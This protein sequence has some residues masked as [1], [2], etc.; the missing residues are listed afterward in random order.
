MSAA[1]PVK[2]HARLEFVDILR[3]FA[4][5]GVL[6][7][8]M[9]SF[10][11]YSS[12]PADYADFLDKAIL[13]GIQFFVRAKFYSLFSFLFGWGMSVQMLRAAGRGQRFGPVFARRMAILLIFG[14]IHGMLIWS[15]DILTLYAILGCALLLFRRR[16]ERLLLVAA[17]LFL[18]V[19]IIL[20]L[21]GEMV[22]AFRTWYAGATAFMRQGNLPDA[23]LA[24]GSYR[25]IVPK[26]TQDFWAAQSWVIYYIGSVF[27]M[28]LLGLYVGKRQIL[29][30][31]DDHLPLLKRTLII[32]LVIGVIFNTI[33]VWNSLHPG[34][35]DPRYDRLVGVGSRAIGAPALMLFYVSGLILLTR[36]ALWLE[37]LRPLG[38]LGRM[39]LSNYLLQSIICV[40]IFYGF[41]LG[42]YGQTDPSFGL[43]VTI[44]IIAGQIRISGWHLARAQFGPM[45]WLWR[46]LTYGRRQRWRVVSGEGRV[47]GG[48]RRVAG[49]E[50]RRVHSLVRLGLVGLI[51]AL[52]AVGLWFWF[53]DSGGGNGVS[54]PPAAQVAATTLPAHVVDQA[55]EEEPP[56][57]VATPQVAQV[58]YTP[59]AAVRSG[60]MAA[61][62]QSFA[63]DRAFE[64][65]EIL[66]GAPYNGRRAGSAG[67]LAAGE[68]L[69]GQFRA[70]GLQPAGDDGTFFQS[71]PISYTNLAAAPQFTVTLPG[72]ETAG[73][74]ALY[75]DYAPIIRDFVGD[76]RGRGDV[77]WMNRCTHDDFGQLNAAGKIALCRLDDDRAALQEASRS[78]VEHGAAGLLLATDPAQRPADMGGNFTH[79]WI[80]EPIPALR[81]YPRLVDDLFLGSGTT[82]SDS[83]LLDAPLP[84]ATQV[85][86]GVQTLGREVCPPLTPA[87]GCSGRNVLAVLPGRDPQFAHEVLILG[88]HYDHLGDS[89]IPAQ[90][91][92]ARTVWAGANDNASGTAVLLE[93]ARGWQEAGYVPRR[94]VLFAAWDAEELGLLGSIHYVRHPQYLPQDVVAMLQLDMVGAGGDILNVS[95][96]DDLIA[97][98][99]TVAGDMDVPYA[100]DPH[101]AQRSHTVHRGR[102]SSRGL[103]LA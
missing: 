53:G 31:V 19:T 83:L 85:D 2:P 92:T 4:L 24:T 5:I 67:G 33:F 66:S 46:T 42:L 81:V 82:I 65:I 45:E 6:A 86:L 97:Q 73:S 28:F 75:E 21:P 38:S 17:V 15:G 27:S 41:G 1:G 90:S 7:A 68:Y 13:I 9:V 43:L 50:G 30:H 29:Q 62:A 14:L 99:Q 96:S 84:L 94:T 102:G 37:R 51:L 76:G 3:G 18:L 77:V 59:G 61:L 47:A 60:D 10:S 88:A 103:D 16:S 8:N 58:V 98:L 40:F 20:T 63:V 87:G 89:P 95:G 74:Y 22:D 36:R 48:E 80:P 93:I 52:S 101:G 57:V 23:I 55:P 25:Q 64:Q 44:L 71:F 35:V 12:N 69:A 34:W 91:G 100:A 54:L 39:A 78:A 70:F 26:T 11:G 56:H 32:G 72:G 49:G 79:S